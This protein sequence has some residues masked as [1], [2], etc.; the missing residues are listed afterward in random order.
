[1]KAKIKALIAFRALF[2]TLL[3]GSSFLF[4]IEYLGSPH[5][6]L[7]S[8]FIIAAYLMTIIYSLLINRVKN[9]LLFGYIQL[10]LDVIAEISLIFI[11]GGIE[12]WFSFTLILTVLSSSIVL[13]K[14]AGYIMASLSS[15]FYGI[16][17]DLQFYKIL[18]IAYEGAMEGKQ[19]LFNIFTH[20]IA[21]YVTAWLAGYLSYSLEKTAE[22]LEEK[23]S[24]LKDL[25]VFNAEVIESLPSGLFT[26]DTNGSVLI[27]NHAAELITG[28][29]KEAV[30]GNAI[31]TVF[32]FLSFPLEGGRYEKILSANTDSEKIIGL[33]IAVLRDRKGNKTG[34]IGIFQDLTQKKQLESEIKNK[35]KWAAIGELSANIAHEIRNPL[36][37]LR[38]SIEMLKEGKL[39]EKH[40]EKLM[41]IALSEMERLNNTISDFLTYSSPKPL[42]IRLVDLHSILDGTLELLKN[43]EHKSGISIKKE[44]EGELLIHADP[45][46]M[47]QV[48][49]NLGVNAFEAME[50]SGV[51]T[52]STK[53]NSKNATISFSDTGSGIAQS[54]I[55]KIFYP[56]FTT[57][58]IGT[59]LG[60]SI[61]YRIIEE[62]NGRLVVASAPGIKTTFEIILMR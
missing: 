40:K 16:L 44:F 3:L 56:F 53:N 5:P 42:D 12:S 51:L 45:E 54:N 41:D 50:D 55:N 59:G 19:F 28:I 21:L 39:P 9:L 2:I 7:I 52:V 61:A 22:K 27:F 4:K 37:S 6:R 57:K 48:F 10:I 26:T 58:V 38:G 14:R 36:A 29:K 31:K 18:P 32:P 11:T 47:R 8:Y 24:S 15:I 43:A 60:L 34:F 13:N 1:M 17:L 25:E 30:T 46:K 33:N 23:D 20:I 35:E 49:W 62:H